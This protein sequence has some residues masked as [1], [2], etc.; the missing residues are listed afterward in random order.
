MALTA[1]VKELVAWCEKKEIAVEAVH[2]TG[3]L[4]VEVD[5]ESRA[6]PDA[7]DWKLDEEVFRKICR[8][9]PTNI[10]LFASPWNTQ[11]DT[12]VSWKPQPGALALNAFILNW[13]KWAAFVFPPFSLIFRCLQKISREK[14]TVVFVCPVWTGQSWY[15]LLLE[16]CCDQPRFLRL[17]RWLLISPLD[18]PHPLLRTRGLLLAAWKLS[19]DVTAC[20][21]F[22]RK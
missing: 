14:A 10:D 19:G 6:G 13:E 16:L 22:R 12:F 2:I 11:L 4:N 17:E 15:P 9:W 3:K 21:D 8:L 1:I 18:D 20:R 7:S 5:V